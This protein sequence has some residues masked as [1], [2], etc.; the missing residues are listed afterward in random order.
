M[1]TVE[2]RDVGNNRPPDH[3]GFEPGKGTAHWGKGNLD[4][5]G[6]VIGKK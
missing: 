5:Q 1:D 3:P 4:G 6:G 2:Y